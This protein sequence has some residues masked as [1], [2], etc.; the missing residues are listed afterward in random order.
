MAIR[1]SQLAV[2]V[3]STVVSNPAAQVAQ[4]AVEFA[5]LPTIPPTKA[6]VDQA[7]IEFAT[8][9][10][11]KAVVDQAAL[12]VATLIPAADSLLPIVFIAT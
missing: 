12:E 4:V 9:T 1:V 10:T 11:P 7:A 3:I 8:V 5:Y 2:E 6:V